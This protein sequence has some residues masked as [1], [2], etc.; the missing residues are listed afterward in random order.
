VVRGTSFKSDFNTIGMKMYQRSRYGNVV[1]VLSTQE[2]R[3]W[4]MQCDSWMPLQSAFLI[5]IDNLVGIACNDQYYTGLPMET[6]KIRS[7]YAQ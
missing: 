3:Y 5:L 7:K 1:T 4:M 2:N 6:I